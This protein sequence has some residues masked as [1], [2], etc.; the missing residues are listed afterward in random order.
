MPT[1]MKMASKIASFSRP[2]VAMC[3]VS[4]TTSLRSNYL[5]YIDVSTDDFPPLH[6]FRKLSTLRMN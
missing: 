2:A 6:S 4:T 1:A 3:K 5:T